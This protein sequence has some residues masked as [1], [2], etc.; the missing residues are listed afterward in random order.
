MFIIIEDSRLVVDYREKQSIA[1]NVEVL[2]DHIKPVLL[3]IVTHYVLS[4]VRV[5][6]F[7]CLLTNHVVDM[8]LKI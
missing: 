6:K 2:I 1:V 4:F 7:H 3:A 5:G 8:S